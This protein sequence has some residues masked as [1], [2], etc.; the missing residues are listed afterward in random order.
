MHAFGNRVT[1][2]LVFGLFAAAPAF[3]APP[4]ALGAADVTSLVAAPSRGSKVLALWSLDCAYCEENLAAL[5]AYQRQHR[6]VELIYVA[7]DPVAQRAALEERL[8]H[9]KLDDVP[10]RA[11]ADAT[12]DRLNFMIDPSWGGETPRTLVIHANGSREAVSGALTPARITTLM[13]D[14]AP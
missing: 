14:T 2:A 7:T 9:A 6:D 5:R 1:N 11:Y 3:A 10:S 4:V 12:P 8:T 13:A